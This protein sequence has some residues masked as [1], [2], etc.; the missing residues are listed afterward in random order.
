V[1]LQVLS[2]MLL[3][4]QD[5]LQYRSSSTHYRRGLAV[6]ETERGAGKGASFVFQ[7]LL[8]DYGETTTV[9]TMPL[10]NVQS[11]L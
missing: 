7:Q 1:P 11:Y 10:C 9:P 4:V 5:E 2:W 8:C 6:T 3:Q